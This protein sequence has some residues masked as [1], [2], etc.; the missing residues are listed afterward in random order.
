MSHRNNANKV[1][2][3]VEVEM[4]KAL[5]V[6]KAVR[7]YVNENGRGCPKGVLQHVN[8]FTA[9]DIKAALDMQLVESGRGSEGGLFP[10]GEK[11][12]A[13][14]RMAVTLKS[15]MVDALRIVADGGT[16]DSDYARNLVSEYEAE[17]AKR[18][19]SQKD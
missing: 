2:G 10:F 8:G 15:R 19:E 4:S 5:E 3:K 12:A 18:S 13:K 7:K 9:K 6:S 14:E 1:C 11:P 16:L 17:L